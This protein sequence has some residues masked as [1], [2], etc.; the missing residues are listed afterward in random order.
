M[1]DISLAYRR[2]LREVGPLRARLRVWKEVVATNWLA[3]RWEGS[4]RPPPPRLVEDL[5]RDLWYGARQLLRSPAFSVGVVATLG[6]GIGAST[7]AYGVVR[8]VLL[9]PLG[10]PGEDRLVMVLS[11]G[12]D[13]G[14]GPTSG[15]D[16]TD[17]RELS[18]SFEA[19]AGYA[20]GP[21]NL[22]GDAE[23]ARVVGARV[24]EDMFR[25]FGVQAAMGRALVPDDHRP[26]AGKAVVLSHGFWQRGFAADSAV[27]GRRVTLNDE[28]HVVVGV[29]PDGFNAPVPWARYDVWTALPAESL[30]DSRDWRHLQVVGRLGSDADVWTAEGDLQTIAERLADEHPVSNRGVTPRVIPLGEAYLGDSRGPLLLLGLAATAV[31]LIVCV[32]VAGMLLARAADR[33]EEVAM[34]RA[35]GAGRGRLIR[36]FLAEGLLLCLVGGAAGILV[37]DWSLSAFGSLLA[38][39]LPRAGEIRLDG[40]VLAFAALVSL[41]VATSLGLAPLV[42]GRMAN[43]VGESRSRHRHGRARA[44]LGK[45]FLAIQFAVTLLLANGAVLM[46]RSYTAVV[47]LELGLDPDGVVTFTLTPEGPRYEDP[48][49]REAFFSDV[50]EHIRSVP[51]VIAAGATSK[52][53]LEGGSNTKVMIE[54]R[55]GEFVQV[56][57][58]LIEL[59]RVMPGYLEAMRIPLVSGRLVEERDFDPRSPGIVISQTMARRLFGTEDPLG[60]RV[61]WETEHPRWLAIVGV[62]G[63]VRQWGIEEAA[64]PEMY[65]PYPVLPR[66]RMFVAVRVD[67]DPLTLIPSIR[68]SVA[69]ADPLLAVSDVRTMDEVRAGAMVDRR[70]NAALAGLLAG[71]ALVLVTAGIYGT[72][73]HHAAR[74]TREIGIRMALGADALGT[75]RRVVTKGMAPALVGVVLGLGAFLWLAPLLGRFVFGVSPLDPATM[76]AATTSVVI[77]GLLACVV[78]ARRAARTDPVESIRAE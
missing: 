77:P 9:R 39:A 76:A 56:R 58:P 46:L 14:R 18:R 41:G 11:E 51:G 10:Y 66:P 15:P 60:Q 57:A 29:M 35:L 38:S 30:A 22:A 67:T 8:G 63:D 45:T 71:I 16:L 28:P 49:R 43:S 36:Q 42:S 75:F 12:A 17:W 52:L 78:P 19:L 31:L 72:M 64:V 68:R 26:R 37:A 69:A 44:R 62:V 53:P 50:L 24:S 73:A 6:I 65:V 61:S 47:G 25:V 21:M 3:F 20:A 32:N 1:E 23:P 13:G 59:S 54:G 40:G 7:A 34:R 33:R 48:R 74:R 27:L 5:R 4:G 70:F 2:D 55:E